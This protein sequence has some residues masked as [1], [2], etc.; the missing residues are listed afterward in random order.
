MIMSHQDNLE[1]RTHKFYTFS[2]NCIKHIQSSIQIE[3]FNTIIQ[4]VFFFYLLHFLLPKYVFNSQH[5]V[6]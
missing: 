5:I 3:V 2:Y 6:I 4:K 1:L